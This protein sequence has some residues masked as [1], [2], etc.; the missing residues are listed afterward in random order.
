MY[1]SC[2]SLDFGS[3][4]GDIGLGFGL[5]SKSITGSFFPA[6]YLLPSPTP[7]ILPLMMRGKLNVLSHLEW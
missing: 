6:P 4:F 5:H 2:L 1:G 3:V 7:R